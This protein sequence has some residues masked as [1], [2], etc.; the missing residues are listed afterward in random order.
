MKLKITL[1]LFFALH[2][3]NAQTKKDSIKINQLEEVIVSSNKVPKSKEFIP[4]QI[5]SILQKE[6]E[7]QN[8]QNTA[9]LLSNSGNLHVQRSQQGGG[10]PAIRGFE[11]SRVL[12][13]V[14]GIR[15]NNLIFRSGHLQ[16]AITVDENLLE[17]VDIFYGPTSTLF[18]SDALGGTVSMNTKKAKYLT[19]KKSF[20]TGNISERYSSVNE[21]KSSYL[22]FNFAGTNWSS[23]TA[24]SYND[25][26]DLKMGEKRNKNNSF[27]GER[28]YYVKNV[29]GVDILITNNDKYVQKN[30][31]YKQYN[32]MQK[33]AYKTNK[34][35]EHGL[36]FQ[37]STSTD[38]PRY[39]RLTDASSSTGLKNA[40]WFYG[41]QKRLLAIYSLSKEK[42]IFNSNLKVD[43]AYQNIEESRHNRR[44]GNYNLQ[45]RIEKVNMFSMSV[46]LNKK[47]TKG[48][49][50]YGYESYYETLDSKAYSNNINT[51]VTSPIDTRYPNGDNYMLR[52][53][54]YV[55]YN[56]KATSKTA[57]NL[58]ARAGYTLLH[59]SINDDAFFPLPFN[60]INQRNFTYSATAG[61]IHQPS[62]NVDLKTNISSGFRVPNIDDLGKIFESG[63]GY[64]IVPNAD[65]SPEK[66]ITTDLGFVIKTNNKRF[67]L[68]YT[69]FY[70]KFIDAIVT[71]N[72]TY[73]GQ[74][75]ILY[76]GNTS[77]VLANQNKGKAFVTG[78]STNLKAYIFDNLQFKGSFNYTLGRITEE[79][80]RSPLDHIP[81]FYGK[82]GFNYTKKWGTL[83]A[84]VLYNGK[85][86]I[87]N[88]YLN[89][90]DNEQYA[91]IGG[92]PSWE[93]YNIKTAFSLF[94]GG[95]IFGG[96]ENI[97]DA[98]Y[99]VFASGINSPGRN[100][101]CGLKY[102]F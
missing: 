1:L 25:F 22:D 56:E 26:G 67:K 31:A 94:K 17:N 80:D 41:P 13:V 78:F 32:F 73:E 95:T 89:G 46:D 5:E 9:D 92:M 98:Q 75:T 79:N 81:P 35:F 55:S 91:P 37:Y 86:A 36:N 39:D 18:G 8:Y 52:N 69:Y 30:T 97:L 48:E 2:L 10:S 23:L 45:N 68:E 77:Q 51:G 40:E 3:L 88:Y 63:G 84:Y 87:K 65:L 93:T 47:F 74:S 90:E 7:F 76:N 85:K 44:F 59:S 72:F 61:L 96:I 71:D 20:F 70:T 57:W 101:Y 14:D 43:L 100:I 34:G 83:E 12:L 4:I 82:L 28:D 42:A 53:D 54:L 27:F 49:L 21:E 29:N 60:T 50:F 19:E 66:T 38:V 6:I 11:S 24:F 33:F 58:G 15:M 102:S 62:K 16:N 64:I 99:R